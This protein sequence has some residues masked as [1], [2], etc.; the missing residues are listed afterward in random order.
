MTRSVY[1][2]ASTTQVAASRSGRSPRRARSRLD[3]GAVN[4]ELFGARVLHGPGERFRSV[5][6]LLGCPV[7]PRVEE[8]AG[9]GRRPR[10]RTGRRRAD[11]SHEACVWPRARQAWQGNPGVGV[12]MECRAAYATKY[13]PTIDVGTSAGVGRERPST[14]PSHRGGRRRCP[15]LADE[16]AYRLATMC[17]LRQSGLACGLWWRPETPRDPQRRSATTP[18]SPGRCQP[19]AR[20]SPALCASPDDARVEGDR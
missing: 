16:R 2:T 7:P 15:D 20:S 1:S 10:R 14:T 6:P 19:T 3:R 5:A 11:R 12:R 9:I 17:R 13:T 4:V 18:T 8:T